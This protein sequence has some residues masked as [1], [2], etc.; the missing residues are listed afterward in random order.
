M[1]GTKSYLDPIYKDHYTW[2]KDK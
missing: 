2:C 1:K